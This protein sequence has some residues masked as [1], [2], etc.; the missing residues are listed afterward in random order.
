MPL[1]F[2]DPKL[3]RFQ[4]ASMVLSD[5]MPDLKKW[6]HMFEIRDMTMNE[7]AQQH[8]DEEIAEVLGGPECDEVIRAVQLHAGTPSSYDTER[9]LKGKEHP[10]IRKSITSF[11]KKLKDYLNK[12]YHVICEHYFMEAVS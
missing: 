4:L 3:I 1:N 6:K 8:F 5:K 9:I 11:R 12:K 2:H 10:V 7:K